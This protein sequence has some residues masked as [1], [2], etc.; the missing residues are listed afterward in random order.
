MARFVRPPTPVLVV[1]ALGIIVWLLP[2]SCT[3]ASAQVVVAKK[4]AVQSVAAKKDT[5]VPARKFKGQYR[6]F[7]VSGSDFRIPKGEIEGLE[8]GLFFVHTLNDQFWAFYAEAEWLPLEKRTI[9]LVRLSAKSPFGAQLPEFREAP[10]AAVLEEMEG[11]WDGCKNFLA[12]ALTPD[13]YWFVLTK[14][15]S[16]LRS[17]EHK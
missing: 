13:A 8:G 2:D 1:L 10:A 9:Y 7:G 5:L 17:R 3:R 15:A 16:F 12:T 11:S 14:V 4:L 6:N